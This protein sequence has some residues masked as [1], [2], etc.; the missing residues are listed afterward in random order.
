MAILS[1]DE[2]LDFKKLGFVVFLT[3]KGI[4]IRNILLK[5]KLS[6]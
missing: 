4:L 6:P 1:P 2:I 5:S 3:M